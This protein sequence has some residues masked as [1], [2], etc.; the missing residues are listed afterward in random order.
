MTPR[1]LS[2][3]KEHEKKSSITPLSQLPS[4]SA[5]KMAMK[6]VEEEGDV[7]PGHERG[8]GD[9]DVVNTYDDN[10]ISPYT[11]ADDENWYAPKFM[12]NESFEVAISP[13]RGMGKGCVMKKIFST[14]PY[15]DGKAVYGGKGHF[16]KVPAKMAE[17]AEKEARALL[18]Q[19]RKTL[20]AKQI[21]TSSTFVNH[22]DYI[23]P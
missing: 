9:E 20:L 5:A 7:E 16:E 18:V 1:F 14:K 15:V 12:D 22:D 23:K 10:D 2:Y 19:Q 17:T 4:K 11:S 21:G 8:V 13:G 6:D 3:K